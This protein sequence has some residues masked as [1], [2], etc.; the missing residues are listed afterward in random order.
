MAH[1]FEQQAWIGMGVEHIEHFFNVLT[2]PSY[3][4]SLNHGKLIREAGER[5]NEMMCSCVGHYLVEYFA[6][7]LA[8][9]Q[10]SESAQWCMEDVLE[11]DVLEMVHQTMFALKR[12]HVVERLT[13]VKSGH[14]TLTATGLLELLK[15]P[16]REVAVIHG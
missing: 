10:L 13:I 8:P 6:K 7:I 3:V 16:E 15:H 1:N 9:M 4:F 5:V 14:V 12:G 11:W 2:M